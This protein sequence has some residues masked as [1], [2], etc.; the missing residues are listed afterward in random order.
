MSSFNHWPE[1][2]FGMTRDENMDDVLQALKLKV[3]RQP[4][5]AAYIALA[6]AYAQSGE[7]A[8]AQRI[9]DMLRRESR[10]THHDE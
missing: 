3:G 7:H 1:S 6:E 5:R 9:I 8:E 4:D 2:E 10:E